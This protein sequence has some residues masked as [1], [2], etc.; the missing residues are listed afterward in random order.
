[1]SLFVTLHP[2]DA[3]FSNLLAQEE[4]NS[5]LLE[6]DVSIVAGNVST[7]SA[8]GAA[9]LMTI[10][11]SRRRELED[12]DECSILARESSIDSSELSR[13]NSATSDFELRYAI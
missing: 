5:S 4:A 2:F 8:E 12:N 6:E 10:V 1:M 7:L 3:L 9:T 13:Q 11:D